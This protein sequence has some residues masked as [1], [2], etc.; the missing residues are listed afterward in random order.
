MKRRSVGSVLHELAQ[1][2]PAR[3]HPAPSTLDEKIIQRM[4]AARIGGEQPVTRGVKRGWRITR[5]IV[6]AAGSVLIAVAVVLPLRGLRS[7]HSGPSGIGAGPAPTSPVW[8]AHTIE[9]VSIDM[10]DTWSFKVHPVP[11]LIEPDLMFAWGTWGF[12]TGGDCGP[13]AALGDLGPDGAFAWLTEYPA[14]QIP[15]QME[16]A[17][18]PKPGQFS[19]ASSDLSPRECAGEAPSHRLGFRLNGRYFEAHV[20]FGADASR[21]TK[22]D[23]LASLDSIDATAT[24]R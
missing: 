23:M 1:I 11:H 17:F 4:R 5:P 3:G 24:S 8:I 20:A 16:T 22:D 21:Q 7:S 6:L 9:G 12:P 14:D 10:P 19:F 18:P 15:P 13:D 2:D